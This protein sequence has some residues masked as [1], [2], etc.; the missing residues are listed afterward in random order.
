MSSQEFPPQSQ[1]PSPIR[2]VNQ[3]HFLKSIIAGLGAPIVFLDRL[4]RGIIPTA[5]AQESEAT[6]AIPEYKRQLT[7]LSDRPLNA[8][9]PAHLLDDLVTPNHLHFVRNNGHIP[10]R[11]QTKDLAGWKLKIDGEVNKSRIFTIE[12][13]KREFEHR[14]AFITIECAGNGRAGYY[15]NASGNQWTLG[16]VGCAQYRGIRLGDVLRSLGVKSSAVYIGYYGEDPHLSRDPAKSPIS[17]GVPIE[18]ALDPHTLLAWEMNGEPLPAEHGFPLR[19]ICP[20]WPGSTCGKWLNRIWVRDQ[21]HDGTKM[22]G[23]AYRTP[24]HPVAPGVAVAES[25]MEII[26]IMPVKSLITSPKTGLNTPQEQPFEMR[27]HAW[28]GSGDIA[29]V[30]VTF[31][32]GST[33]QPT[34][35]LPAKNR[36]AWQRW[37]TTLQ[38]PKKGYYEVWARATDKEGNSQPMI[39]PG[40]NPKGYLNNA[41]HRI[42]VKAV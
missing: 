2:R 5:L 29:R 16:A 36:Y 38:F 22:T 12:S 31:D 18:K 4:P 28:S 6:M 32:F 40:W 11:A 20:G 15:P 41:M 25:D 37:S 21:V 17:R 3:R 1:A 8:E 30:D 39:V 26:T 10:D 27:G 19:L 33:W 42:A 23:S 24:R 34:T 9:T 7:I 13:L 14:E 35:L